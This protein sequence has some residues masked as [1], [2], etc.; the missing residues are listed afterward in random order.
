MTQPLYKLKVK[1]VV[2]KSVT[3][4]CATKTLVRRQYVLQGTRVCCINLLKV[5]RGRAVT[6]M[7]VNCQSDASRWYVPGFQKSCP[8]VLQIATC[9]PVFKVKM[10]AVSSPRGVNVTSAPQNCAPV[11]YGFRYWW[12]GV[13]P[14]GNAA[15]S[16]DVSM[17][18]T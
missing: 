3:N 5:I 2:V 18:L 1:T 8:S 15:A 13:V 12:R 16:T 17:R 4:V 14:P 10:V 6:S 7:S 9:C 11:G